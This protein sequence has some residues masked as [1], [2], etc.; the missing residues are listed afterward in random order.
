GAAL[1]ADA[2]RVGRAHAALAGRDAGEEA[3][4]RGRLG[5]VVR[6]RVAEV[7]AAG[8][9]GLRGR[10]AHRGRPG[11]GG[12]LGGGALHAGVRG[13]VADRLRAL[14]GGVGDALDAEARV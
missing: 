10:R 8:A 13:G 9:A 1:V 5:A 7:T 14:A 2:V 6:R 12:R 4:R 11:A 3:V